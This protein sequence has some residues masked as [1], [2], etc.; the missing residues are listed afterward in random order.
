[1]TTPGLR[2]IGTGVALPDKVL[3]NADIRRFNPAVDCDFVAERLGILERRVAD[4][5][6]QTSDLAAAAAREALAQAGVGPDSVDLFILAT[7]TP[8]RQAPATACIAQAKAGLVNAVSFD[9]GAV[10][11]GFLY[12]LA[13]AAAFIRSGQARR[14][15]VVGADVFSR[16]TDW[17]RRDCVFFGDGAG[18]AL[19]EGLERED[20]LF[21]AHLHSDGSRSDAFT[22]VPGA[23]HFSMDAPGVLEA[24]LDAVPLCVEAVLARNGLCAQDVDL[25]VPHQ[26]S[27]NLLR[28]IAWRT[29]VPFQKFRTNMDRYANTAGATIPIALHESVQQ[30]AIEEGD[31]VLFAAAGAGFTAGAAIHRWH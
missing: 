9:V 20:G 31:L 15:L 2:F 27:V 21:D 5:Q 18:A 6:T 7:A 30:G 8:D 26:P 4:P 1:M 22:V 14:A 16:I 24:A 29:G 28:K 19:V 12:G 10:C 3:T 11:S 13:T 23:R 25:V 17:S